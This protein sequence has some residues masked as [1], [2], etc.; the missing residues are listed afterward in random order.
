MVSDKQRR[1]RALES[2]DFSFGKTRNED[3]YFLGC[4]G[5]LVDSDKLQE[6]HSVGNVAAVYDS[7]KCPHGTVVKTTSVA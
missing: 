4:E 6:V 3:A 5:V 2:R 1:V 7:C